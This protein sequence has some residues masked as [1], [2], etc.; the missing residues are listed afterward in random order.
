[1]KLQV[2]RYSTGP[3]ETL[4]LLFDVEDGRKF[5][6]YT[7]EDAFQEEK[8]P[9]R[10]RI[11]AGV[12]EIKLRTVGGHHRRYT[13]KFPSIHKGMLWLQDVPDFTFVLIH[14]GNTNDDTAGCLLVG[15]SVTES[16]TLTG[17]TKAYER[18]YSHVVSAFEKGE[19]VFIEFIDYDTP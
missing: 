4:G 11:P 1:M 13:K 14:I 17:S 18:V 16:R 2:V 7:L 5:L 10:T 6:A 3:N 8:V 19:R 12:Y 9:E 15:S